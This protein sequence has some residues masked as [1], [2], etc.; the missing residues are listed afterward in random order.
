MKKM[1]FVLCLLLG[2]SGAGHAQ[3]QE[4]RITV[5]DGF[6]WSNG[7]PDGQIDA[8]IAAEFIATDDLQAYNLTVA[9]NAK[10]TMTGS[11]RLILFNDCD[12]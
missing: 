10:L 7:V 4:R 11:S 8:I 9:A 3:N 2:F 1:Y 6:Q 5:W 12:C